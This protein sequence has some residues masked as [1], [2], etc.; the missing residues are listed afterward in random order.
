MMSLLDKLMVNLSGHGRIK[1]GKILPGK[2]SPGLTGVFV[3]SDER[4]ECGPE[5]VEGGAEMLK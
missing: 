5:V 4:M 1:N 2:G 3:S